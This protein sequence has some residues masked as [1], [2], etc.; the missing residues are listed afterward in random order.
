MSIFYEE[1]KKKA[2]DESKNNEMV[3]VG[4][5]AYTN[6]PFNYFGMTYS[7]VLEY[8]DSYI[9]VFKNPQFT[10]QPIAGR[11]KYIIVDNSINSICSIIALLECGATPVIIDGKNIP[12][13]DKNKFPYLEYGDEVEGCEIEDKLVEYYL[14]T[15]SIDKNL[16]GEEKPG[17]KLIICSSGSE[18]ATPH[19]NLIYEEDLVK[20]PNQYG[21]NDSTFLSYISC[22]NISGILTNLV[23][24][25][26]HDTKLLL[27]QNFDL[28][29]VYF[30]NDYDK[31]LK[32]NF[33]RK[34][35]EKRY[36]CSTANPALMKLLFH[37]PKSCDGMFCDQ[38]HLEGDELVVPEMREDYQVIL[39][40]DKFSNK[41]ING[42]IPHADTMMFPRNITSYLE[43][44]NL[45]GIDL[46]S[47]R[48]I[49]LSGGINSEDVVKKVRE[50]IPSITEGVFTNLYGSTEANGVICS[51]DEK[52]F[53][54]CYINVGD[55]ESGKIS[56]TFDKEKFY[57]IENG[58]TREIDIPEDMF[59][60]MPYLNVSSKKEEKV[61]VD[62]KL[63][64]KYNG[65]ETGDFGIYIDNQLYVL[66]RKSDFIKLNGRTYVAHSLESYYSNEIGANVY[67]RPIDEEGI[68]PFIKESPI[69]ITQKFL[70]KYEKALNISL[71]EKRF[72]VNPPVI[73]DDYIFPES[74]ISGKIP[75]SY[76]HLYEEYAKEQSEN[77]FDFPNSITKKSKE[78]AKSMANYSPVVLKDGSFLIEM[79]KRLV[80]PINDIILSFYKPVFTEDEDLIRFV[81]K[82]E[83]IF[84]TQEHIAFCNKKA[85]DDLNHGIAE[86]ILSKLYKCINNG[87]DV[88]S[89][90][91]K[92]DENLTG[93]KLVEQLKCNIMADFA[94]RYTNKLKYKIMLELLNKEESGKFE[95]E[96]PT[97]EGSIENQTKD[98]VDSQGNKLVKK[99]SNSKNEQKSKEE[100]D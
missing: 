42:N 78:F 32:K 14:K 71:N 56:Y 21:E 3:I 82:P 16:P 6:V 76:L 70:K 84:M 7:E 60:Y 77:F 1:L 59:E 65:Q 24:F 19:L 44:A 8:V 87:I 4:K 9:E 25:L 47:M 49:Y 35:N 72:H 38:I 22:A 96:L 93:E 12:G 54:T 74:K 5:L 26:M 45:E 88:M 20:L 80:I 39:M 50:M 61:S 52:D 92:I 75:K 91:Q 99:K 85:I 51:C 2:S 27:S 30:A 97:S 90:K 48:H 68:Q 98:E 94:R 66:G 18:G 28:E 63:K 57:E 58:I 86:P 29:T 55:Y 17:G 62:N 34:Y 40:N 13:I 11:R 83:I 53:K 89:K 31:F 95:N 37:N 36:F 81:P 10:M 67:I 100:K 73:I 64:I 79:S 23:N 46:S 43:K 33:I 15:L 41:V 69:K